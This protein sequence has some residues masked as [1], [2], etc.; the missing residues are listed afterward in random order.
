[1]EQFYSDTV[2]DELKKIYKDRK[3]LLKT[4]TA[5]YKDMF[6]VKKPIAPKTNDL[7]I[8]SYSLDLNSIF[9]EHK[10]YIDDTKDYI[11]TIMK[12]TSMIPSFL[13]FCYIY[14]VTH[15][16]SDAPFHKLPSTKT[17]YR[18][19]ISTLQA[20]QNPINLILEKIILDDLFR[21]IRIESPPFHIR[22]ELSNE[23]V[24]E[25]LESHIKP[26]CKELYESI[27]RLK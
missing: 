25:Q 4:I 15:Y 7:P 2:A 12:S 3:N 5:M 21:E 18:L 20:N 13:D 9:S 10:Q 16:D 8:N 24:V 26:M 17:K 27:L 1:M 14:Y 6:G 22:T 11:D 19:I 23:E